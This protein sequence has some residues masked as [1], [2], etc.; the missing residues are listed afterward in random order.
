[1]MRPTILVD[2]D[3]PLTRGFA[4]EACRI[5]RD[6]GVAHAEPDR[7]MQWD[8]ARSFGADA[9]T[10]AS[11]M[12]RLRREG[13][14]TSFDPREGA[15]EALESLR[16]WARVV[17]VTA[18]LPGSRT[19]VGERMVW[20]QILL[21]FRAADVVHADDKSLVAGDALVEDRLE[22]LAA[23]G[24]RWPGKAQ[25]LWDAPYNQVSP[26]GTPWFLRV[27][28]PEGM[29]AALEMLLKPKWGGI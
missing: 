2:V 9:P 3:G 27:D 24:E 15:L 14:A 25:I 12:V 18:P 1:M 10:A 13:V 28:N 5:L 17:A 4:R 22:N 23:W 26:P 6:L 11:M 19:W 29:R 8:V 7:I 21:G 16:E 20:L